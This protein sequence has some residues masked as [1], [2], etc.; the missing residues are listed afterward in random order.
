MLAGLFG[1]LGELGA[2]VLYDC[3]R[4]DQATS[5]LV[6]EQADLA[7]VACRPRLSDLSALRAFFDERAEGS[8]PVL[9]VLVGD[10][11]YPA[12]EVEEALG[13]DVAGQLPFDPEAAAAIGTLPVSSRQLTRTPL[14]RALRTLAEALAGRLAHAAPDRPVP[15][16]LARSGSGHA[17]LGG[18]R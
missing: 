14:V 3:G 6:F 10:G 17:H 11:P 18:R 4:L 8:R 1:R 9:V 12:K 15:P 13:A 7:V 16:P 5:A 2:V